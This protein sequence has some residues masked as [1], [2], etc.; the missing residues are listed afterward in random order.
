MNIYIDIEKLGFKGYHFHA[1][2]DNWYFKCI[3]VN[4]ECKNEQENKAG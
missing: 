2:I 1:T 3:N 4:K